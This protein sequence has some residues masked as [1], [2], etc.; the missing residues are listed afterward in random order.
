VMGAAAPACSAESR[1]PAGFGEEALKQ[2]E[3][4]F[5]SFQRQIVRERHSRPIQEQLSFDFLADPD[6]PTPSP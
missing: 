2:V 6:E 5:N 1:V 3:D 4:L